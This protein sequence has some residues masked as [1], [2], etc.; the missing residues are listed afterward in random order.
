MEE[1]NRYRISFIGKGEWFIN[2][3][4]FAS[5]DIWLINMSTVKLGR[6]KLGSD[7]RGGEARTYGRADI[8]S[9]TGTIFLPDPP[10][11]SI[12]RIDTEKDRVLEPLLNSGEISSL[13]YCQERGLIF[14]I[15]AGEREVR[16]FRA[17]DPGDRYSAKLDFAPSGI[18]FDGD[19]DILS[20]IGTGEP[21]SG[22]AHARFY[23]FPEFRE[24]QS[25]PV[26]GIPLSTLYDDISDM[27]YILAD[28]PSAI[29]RFVPKNGL[30]TASRSEIPEGSGT[31][32]QI[33]PSDGRILVGTSTGKLLSANTED[34]K[35]EVAASFREPVA[36]ISFNHLVNHLYVAFRDSRDLAVIDLDTMKTREIIRCGAPVSQV[37][38]DEMH[39]KI[40]ILLQD[41]DMIEVY[42]DQGR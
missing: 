35:L 17:S 5:T 14:T 32:M 27:F 38:F 30:R 4:P 8:C 37:L 16:A 34:M 19:R 41:A 12:I 11:S 36:E 31:S 7:R 9:Q 33:C 10:S 42:L 3:T 6:I 20:I 24:L 29:Y 21:G 40:Y 39:N 26:P 1:P 18:S 13:F 2:L 15:H 22:G 25:E 28:S 23:R